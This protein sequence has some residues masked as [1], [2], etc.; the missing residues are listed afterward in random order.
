VFL[1]L[2]LLPLARS[3]FRM[4]RMNQA[5]PL[6]KV[7]IKVAAGAVTA[8]LGS[9]AVVIGLGSRRAACRV[10]HI[11]GHA[12]IRLVG[13]PVTVE[14]L[15]HLAPEQ[16]YVIMANHESSLDIPVLLAAL[17][18]RIELR[19]LAKKS[20][21]AVPFL[22]G[23]MKAAGFIPVD[24]EDRS[25]AAATLAQ[26]LVEIARGGSP[27]IFPEQTWTADGR[28]LPFARG[29]FLIALKSGLPILP[30]GLEGPRIVLPPR[31]GVMRP[32]PMTVRIGKPIPTEGLGVS[33]KTELMARTRR[34][35]DRLR[36]SA[37]HIRD[38]A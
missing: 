37:G 30:I 2:L 27:L 8:L 11:W 19:F 7:L 10:V 36:G 12:L 21:F 34:E 9:L 4:T 20:L 17:P 18:A 3:R 24:R 5:G 1:L 6:K 35:I 25:T 38:G 23:A 29:G 31:A 16:R 33:S 13:A 28:L 26:T 14:G 15:E 22:G 32:R